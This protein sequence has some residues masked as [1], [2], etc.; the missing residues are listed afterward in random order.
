MKRILFAALS[1]LASLLAGCG[2]LTGLVNAHDEFGCGA[3]PGARCNT[4]SENFEKQEKDFHQADSLPVDETS[5]A[6]SSAPEADA[7]GEALVGKKLEKAAREAKT[8]AQKPV[9]RAR[10]TTGARHV[11]SRYRRIVDAFDDPLRASEVVMQLWVM[12][13]VDSDGDFHAAS[14]V[15]LKVKDARWQIERERSRA[16]ADTPDPGEY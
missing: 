15:W 14:R 3:P 8:V 1:V 12:P 4:L 13:W 5:E 7:K 2:N 16:V 11:D 10:A 6:I 9:V